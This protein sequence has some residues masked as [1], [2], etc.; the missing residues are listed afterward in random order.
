MR[1]GTLLLA[2]VLLLLTGCASGST[3]RTTGNVTRKTD[4]RTSTFK[5]VNTTPYADV[6]VLTNL[7]E[8][9][10]TWEIISP[11]GRSF[12]RDTAVAGRKFRETRR[13]GVI[14]PGEW[15]VNITMEGATGSYEVNARAPER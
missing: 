12:W 15:T 10:L 5:M 13:L 14:I 1:T 7:S 9:S 2:I 8:G 3:A 11:D 4:T 6:T